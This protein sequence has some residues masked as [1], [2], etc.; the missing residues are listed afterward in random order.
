MKKFE[1]TRLGY[2]LPTNLIYIVYFEVYH[3]FAKGSIRFIINMFFF[4]VKIGKGKVKIA[5]MDTSF[6]H[7]GNFYPSLYNK[8]LLDEK[9]AVL[10]KEQLKSGNN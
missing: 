2:N 8:Q 9:I 3:R 4:F 6:A 5:S 1:L 10:V 7:K